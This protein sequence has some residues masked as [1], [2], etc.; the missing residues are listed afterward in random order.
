[1]GSK[2]GK[3]KAA[4]RK[5]ASLAHVLGQSEQV[6]E[7][8][9]EAAAELTS[10]NE[11]LQHEEEATVPPK[12]I[13]QAVAQ[14]KEAEGKVVQAADDLTQ[15]NAGLAEVVTQRTAIESELADVKKDLASARQDLSTAEAEHEE[16]RQ[17]A[18]QDP[19]TGLP[20]RAL[21]EQALE[22]GLLQAGRHGWGL[23][24]LVIDVDDFKSY[25]DSHGHDIGDKVLL[26][27]AERLR[28][29]VRDG[30]LVS[31]WG[32]DEFACLLLEV[33]AEADVRQLAGTMVKAIAEPGELGGT[34]V[35]IPVSIGIAIHPADGDAPEVLFK[36]AD[37][38][39]Y[40]AKRLASHVQV[41]RDGP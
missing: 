36:K 11:M 5:G 25:N 6:A 32:G 24:V 21:F 38:A 29:V 31:R 12:T 16:T 19:L 9:Q 18:L 35:S 14:N 33:K 30:D 34:E 2:S 17:L 8:I 27:V 26:R 13:R 10:V 1:M 15:V 39:M 23:A 7:S 4:A 3:S 40:Q 22:Q 20:N 28:S 41:Y 37:T